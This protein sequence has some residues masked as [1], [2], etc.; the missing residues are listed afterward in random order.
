VALD[1][2]ERRDEMGALD[3]LRALVADPARTEDVER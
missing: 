1:D 2:L 3:R